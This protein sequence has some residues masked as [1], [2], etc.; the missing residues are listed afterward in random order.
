MPSVC[1]GL[2]FQLLHLWGWKTCMVVIHIQKKLKNVFDI[3]ERLTLRQTLP[4]PPSCLLRCTTVQWTSLGTE[5]I[6]SF[7][8][9]KFSGNNSVSCLKDEIIC[10]CKYV[11]NCYQPCLVFWHDCFE[12][13]Y[14]TTSVVVIL[15]NA[16]GVKIAQRHY[17]S[18]SAILV[19]VIMIVNLQLLDDDVWLDVFCAC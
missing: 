2:R 9:V 5:L 6:S 4:A 10:T 14:S 1:C 8:S 3:I 17:R 13:F 11:S 19:I 12:N 18:K 7:H 15:I 16:I